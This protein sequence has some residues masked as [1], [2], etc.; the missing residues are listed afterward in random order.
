MIASVERLEPRFRPVTA[1]IANST[2]AAD[3]GR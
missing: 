1:N 2:A 3:A